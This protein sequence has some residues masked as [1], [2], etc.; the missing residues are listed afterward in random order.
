MVY[1]KPSKKQ[2]VASIFLLKRSLVTEEVKSVM[3]DCFNEGDA[4]EAQILLAGQKYLERPSVLHNVL[5]DLFVVLRYK[6][7]NNL[8][9]ALDICLLAMDRFV[10]SR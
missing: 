1:T 7:W 8:K 3:P 10:F 4:S 5:N 9:Q 6:T 2:A